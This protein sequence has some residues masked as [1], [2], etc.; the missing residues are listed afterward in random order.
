M[1]KQQQ[2]LFM[3]R[4]ENDELKA[5]LE[6]QNLIIER[7]RHELEQRKSLEMTSKIAFN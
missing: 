1:E 7:L 3:L 2:E 4:K 5:K 6:K